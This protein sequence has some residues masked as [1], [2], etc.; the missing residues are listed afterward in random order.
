MD[1]PWKINYQINRRDFWLDEYFSYFYHPWV[2][3]VI[4]LLLALMSYFFVHALLLTHSLTIATKVLLPQHTFSW[5]ALAGMALRILSRMPPRD[6]VRHC[7]ATIDTQRFCCAEP[8]KIYRFPWKKV[9]TIRQ[10]PDYLLFFTWN[11]GTFTVPIRAFE[12]L[13]E[14]Q[15]FRQAAQRLKHVPK[16]GQFAVPHDKTVWPPAPRP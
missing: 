2:R 16:K 12:S 7:S 14:A 11:G 10:T 8:Q 5:L 15:R 6:G 13:E 1:K 9:M 4:S 3:Y